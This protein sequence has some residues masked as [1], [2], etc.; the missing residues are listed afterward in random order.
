MS[1]DWSRSSAPPRS[2]AAH[3]F[4]L[5]P[6]VSLLFQ[7]AER[8]VLALL[9]AMDQL[10]NGTRFLQHSSR[11]E[12]P[13]SEGVVRQWVRGVQAWRE[14]LHL[15]GWS[16][17]DQVRALLRLDPLSSAESLALTYLPVECVYGFWLPRVAV[18]PLPVQEWF[19]EVNAEGVP[20]TDSVPLSVGSSSQGATPIRL[21][22]RAYDAPLTRMD[23]IRRSRVLGRVLA[24]GR[25]IR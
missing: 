25:L 10:R 15:F 21:V 20:P 9:S 11:L 19:H 2:G 5:T 23:N 1:V 22:A 4:A 14:G 3:L 18:R 16:W 13:S 12:L 6:E 24:S 17:R 8:P 7:R